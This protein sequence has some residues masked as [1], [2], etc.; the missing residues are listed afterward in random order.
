MS[1]REQNGRE[2]ASNRQITKDFADPVGKKNIVP[3][4]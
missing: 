2:K 1:S 3:V 4:A